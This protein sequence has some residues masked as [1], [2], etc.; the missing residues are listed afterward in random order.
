MGNSAKIRV[1]IVDDHPVV[2]SSLSLML[3]AEKNIRVVGTALDGIECLA[4]IKKLKPDLVIL[5][6]ALPDIDGIQLMRS[7][8]AN[9]PDTRILIFTGFQNRI[10]S[11]L[12]GGAHGAMMKPSP[13]SEILEGIRIVANGGRYVDRIC[14]RILDAPSLYTD[15]YPKLSDK[16]RE[17]ANLVAQGNT[18]KDIARIKGGSTRTVEKIRCRIMEKFGVKNTACLVAKIVGDLS[19]GSQTLVLF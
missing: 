10:K 16:E 19:D 12:N 17:V 1:L 2:I 13:A 11:A 9:H 8:R 3:K 7:I 15:H 14:S 6:L 5:D 18:S 4:R